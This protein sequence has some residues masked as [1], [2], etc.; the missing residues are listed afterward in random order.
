MIAAMSPEPGPAPVTVSPGPGL[1]LQIANGSQEAMAQLYDQTSSLVYGMA[2]RIV[3]DPAV[4]EEVAM[5]VY[6]QAWRTAV[7]YAAAR[8]SVKAWLATMTRARAIDW[9]RSSQA[10]LVRDGS[11]IEDVPPIAAATPGPEEAAMDSSRQHVLRKHIGALPPEQSRLIELSFF[12]G[13]SHSE[14]AEK[15]G[16]PLGTVKSRIRQGMRRLRDC[17]QTEAWGTN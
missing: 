6:M 1:I 9:L 14:I 2:L 15:L 12:S 8:G 7:Q 16:I 13:F 10:R 5:D 3:R 11:P 4:A 17:F